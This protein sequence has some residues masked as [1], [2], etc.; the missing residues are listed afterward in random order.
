MARIYGIVYTDSKNNTNITVESKH[1]S[2]R[3]EPK[4]YY[5]EFVYIKN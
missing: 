4:R 3:S 1:S 2:L 5:R